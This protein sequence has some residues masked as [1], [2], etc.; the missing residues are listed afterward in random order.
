MPIWRRIL[1]P[2]INSV[3]RPI[4]MPFAAQVDQILGNEGTEVIK[5]Q[6]LIKLDTNIFEAR[7][8]RTIT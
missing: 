1:C 8:I 4:K 6:L 2:V 5:N 3:L 7:K